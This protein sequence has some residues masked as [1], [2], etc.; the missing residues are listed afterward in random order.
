MA[1]ALSLGL[2]FMPSLATSASASTFANAVITDA[3]TANSAT[4][5]RI[6]IVRGSNI[7]LV[8]TQ[9]RVPIQIRNNYDT[10]VK[11]L[12]WARPSN[13]RIAMPKAIAFT[14]PANTTSNATIPVEAIANG[15]VRLNVWLT[16]FSGVPIGHPTVLNM[17]VQRDIEGSILI[18][19]FAVVGTLGFIGG[20]RMLKRRREVN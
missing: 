13:A 19:F 20:R 16:S 4:D 17:T 12:I 3:R 10:D 7:N 5:F 11:V 14:A 18:G 1:T 8:S 9:S 15:E 2:A 6:E